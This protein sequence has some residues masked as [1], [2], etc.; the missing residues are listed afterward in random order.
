MFLLVNDALVS[1]VDNLAVTNAATATANSALDE[2]IEYYEEELDFY[3]TGNGV[4][5]DDFNETYYDA[6]TKLWKLLMQ[7]KALTR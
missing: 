2:M 6:Y 7:L 5:E 4:N 3:V 1:A